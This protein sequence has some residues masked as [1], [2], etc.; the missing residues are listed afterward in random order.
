VTS[1]TVGGRGHFGHGGTPSPSAAGSTAGQVDS[2]QYLTITA[3]ITD[4]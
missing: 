3:R 1:E 2:D 4:I